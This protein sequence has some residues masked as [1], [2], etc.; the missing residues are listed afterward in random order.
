MKR[1]LLLMM[2]CLM[3]VCMNAQHQQL[4]DEFLQEAGDQAEMF[5]GKVEPGYSPMVYINHPYW[6]SDDFLSGD[7]V[8]HGLNYRGV[9]LRYDAYLKQLVV[10]TPVKRSNVIIPMDRVEKFT[11]DGI[12]YERRNGEMMVVLYSS[13]RIELVERMN[14]SVREKF[15][16]NVKVQYEFERDM[17]YCLLRDGQTY[18]VSNLKSVSKLY[19]SIKKELKRFAKTYRL[20]FKEHSQSSLTTIV[21]YVDELLAQP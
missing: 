21:K 19:P 11:M 8:Y 18:E 6:L 20:N 12:A 17:I 15:V 2:G 7:V 5:A 1:F 4:F 16:D 10:K 3:C 14:V 9:S 13:P